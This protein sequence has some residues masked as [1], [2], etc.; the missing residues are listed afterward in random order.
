MEFH[1]NLIMQ[2]LADF[3]L[4]MARVSGVFMIMAGLGTRNVPM[5]IRVLLI[6]S[7]TFMIMPVIP[8]VPNPELMSFRMVLQV[9]QQVTIGFAIGFMTLIF[10]NTFIV[11]GQVLATQSGLAF[12]SM[13]DP[14][15]GI[16]VP[17]IGQFYLILATLLFFIFDGH[18]ITIQML[19]MSFDTLPIVDAWW[20]VLQIWAIIEFSGWMFATAL[21]ITLAPIIAMLVV[22]LSFGIMTR[23]APQL[24]IFAIGFPITMLS[25]LLIL[26]LTLDTFLIHYGIQWQMTLDYTCRVIGC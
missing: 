26:W 2:T 6:V 24:N 9:M 25:G 5:R 12:A 8:P 18:L 1:L 3:L 14:A 21:S 20:S 4:P 16:S 17:A 13:V 22:N 23:A 15:S 11:A 10:I 19:V 7:L